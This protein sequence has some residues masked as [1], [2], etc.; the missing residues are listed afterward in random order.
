[1]HEVDINELC[2]S[3]YCFFYEDINQN[4]TVY[5]KL[6]QLLEMHV[7]T[8]S[9]NPKKTVKEDL[10]P[11]SKDLIPTFSEKLSVLG[12]SLFFFHFYNSVVG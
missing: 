8:S 7:P 4:E 1:M 3:S 11:V 2:D 6:G 12:S 9:E 5:R 10:H